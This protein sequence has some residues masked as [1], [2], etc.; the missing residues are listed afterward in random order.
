MKSPISNVLSRLHKVKRTGADKWQALCP[1]HDDRRPSLSIREAEDGKVLLKCWTGCE[2]AEIVDALGLGLVDLFPDDR[3]SL[4]N[5]CTGPMRRPFDYR[6]ALQ[7]IS[8]EA[9]VARL[10]VAAI[11][12]GDKIDPESLNRLAQ[13]EQRIDAALRAVGGVQ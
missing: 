4:S 11:N 12:R 1:A 10:I 9:T 7:G 2:V 8:H 6:E 13:A 5:H 3:R